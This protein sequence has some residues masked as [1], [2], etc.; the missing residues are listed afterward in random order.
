MWILRAWNPRTYGMHATLPR[1]SLCGRM[2]G[3]DGPS[4][5]QGRTPIRPINHDMSVTYAII[6]TNTA[7]TI[8]MISPRRATTESDHWTD[9]AIA[10]HPESAPPKQDLHTDAYQPPQHGAYRTL[11][12]C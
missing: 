5:Y 8:A 11:R 12:L 1:P 9:S 4:W 3:A 7:A 6:P 10:R 2:L